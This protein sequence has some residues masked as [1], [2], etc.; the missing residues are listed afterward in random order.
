MILEDRLTL[1][2]YVVFQS[3][4]GEKHLVTLLCNCCC[5]TL[6]IWEEKKIPTCFSFVLLLPRLP[7]VE[8]SSEFGQKQK[9]RVFCVYKTARER[10]TLGWDEIQRGCVRVCVCWMCFLI[11][12]LRSKVK[13]WGELNGNQFLLQQALLLPK[14]RALSENKWFLMN[15]CS[16]LKWC[17]TSF[18]SFSTLA[19]V[20]VDMAASALPFPKITCHSDRRNRPIP[21][22]YCSEKSK[23]WLIIPD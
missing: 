18:L 15:N 20:K 7:R 3:N 4:N 5:E 14:D 19:A 2:R 16:N 22:L 8:I 10:E 21:L 11:A 6:K 13:L 1:C 23:V 17:S 12:V 9:R